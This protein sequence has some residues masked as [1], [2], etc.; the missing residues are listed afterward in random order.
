MHEIVETQ[1]KF[2]LTHVT[3]DIDF[4]LRALKS[5]QKTIR[6]WEPRICEALHAD[7]GKSAA[8]GYMCEIGLV[9]GSLRDTLKNLRKWSKPRRVMASLAHFLPC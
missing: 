4:R 6:E 8:E 5:L 3:R 9:L 2:F 1:R 7:L